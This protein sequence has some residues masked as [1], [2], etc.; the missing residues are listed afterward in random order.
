MRAEMD[1]YQAVRH[2]NPTKLKVKTRVIAPGEDPVLAATTGRTVPL[3]QP[4]EGSSAQPQQILNP[5][6]LRSVMVDIQ[7]QPK[8]DDVNSADV[9]EA[10][11][12]AMAEG[13][14]EE[15]AATRLERKRKID[16]LT[17]GLS[18]KAKP[19]AAGPSQVETF[20]V[21]NDTQSSTAKEVQDTA[22]SR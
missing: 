14:K 15:E 12:V 19:D 22:H 5:R 21:D 9:S 1:L 18:K 7:N 11:E 17:S 3:V 13:D 6:P 16:T 4:G 10:Q 8:S 20:N 2:P